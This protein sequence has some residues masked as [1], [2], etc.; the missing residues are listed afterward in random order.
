MFLVSC[1]ASEEP[2][3]YLNNFRKDGMNSSAVCAA[4][5]HLVKGDYIVVSQEDGV[6]ALATG[7]F[8]WTISCRGLYLN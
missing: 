6:M 8:V 3:R 1:S 7:I 5:M 2:S 4:D